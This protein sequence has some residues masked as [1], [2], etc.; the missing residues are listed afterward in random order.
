MTISSEVTYGAGS[1]KMAQDLS[2]AE[3][4]AM[5]DV[6]RDAM[7]D[8][9]LPSFSATTGPGITAPPEWMSSAVG[10][11][12]GQSF[13]I[14]EALYGDSKSDRYILSMQGN[15]WPPI[16][17]EPDDIAP[18]VESYR[19]NMNVGYNAASQPG[20]PPGLAGC[21]C[22]GPKMGLGGCGCR[23]NGLGSDD[24]LDFDLHTTASYN[25]GG[26][27]LSGL[28][29]CDIQ[30]PL[31]LSGMGFDAVEPASEKA[32]R[33]AG[34]KEVLKAALQPTTKFNRE[35][36]RKVID[37]S[38]KLADL[39]EKRAAV[40]QAAAIDQGRS[41]KRAGALD[42][43][44][45]KLALRLF[46]PESG[47]IRDD[48]KAADM[49]KFR[50]LRKAAFD[51]GR[52]AVRDEKVK[53][54][55]KGLAEN[56]YGQSLALQKVAVAMLGNQ[57][58]AVA[59]YGK[60]FDRLGKE[61][62][63]LRAV[64]AKQKA[65]WAQ[66]R[67][68]ELNGLADLDA[69]DSRVASADFWEAELDGME[70]AEDAYLGSLEGWLRRKVKKAASKV[71]SVAKK[72]VSKV[73]SAAK[74]AAARARAAAVA[75][76]KRARDAAK[77]AATAAARRAAAA[78]KKAATKIKN[79]KIVKNTIKVAKPIARTIKATAKVAISPVKM[80]VRAG[81]RIAK[82]DFKG[83]MRSVRDTA[84]GT[85]KQLGSAVTSSVFGVMCAM[86]N[87]RLG[88]AAGQAIG[89]AVG[90][91]Y[92]GTA[93]G[94]VGREAGRKANDLNKGMCK[95][96]KQM[97]LTGDQK[98]NFRA[99]NLKK[100]LKITAKDMKRTTFSKKAMLESAM[101]IAGGMIPG[102]GAAASGALTQLGTKAITDV[103]LNLAKKK[104]QEFL[105]KK[106]GQLA[107]KHA[108]AIT[109]KIVPGKAGRVL[110]K[111]AGGVAST[112]ASGGKIDAAQL[113]RIAATQGK[114]AARR[115]ARK[116]GTRLAKHALGDKTGRLLAE[117]AQMAM[118][119]QGS[120]P[121]QM[122]QRAAAFARKQAADRAQR[123]AQKRLGPA[124][125]LVASA[126]RQASGA[127]KMSAEERRA[128]LVA[129]ARQQAKARGMQAARRQ[130]GTKQV[131]MAQRA[132]RGGRPDTRAAAVSF[133]RQQAR[134]PW[135][136]TGP[137][138]SSLFRMARRRG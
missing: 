85:I 18:T 119:A 7:P 80:T 52:R 68:H 16:W 67:V 117:G 96:M 88:R 55:A 3:D 53:Q 62:G 102:G 32:R 65:N 33:E 92:G 98:L 9:D 73:S 47:D 70:I 19:N 133:A 36:A 40:A 107:G 94:S 76:A 39:V 79:S 111:A 75:A 60:V 44:T 63:A 31:G 135:G 14:D 69:I 116:Q 58:D 120:N 113:R 66:T 95:G 21:G 109:R 138:S 134:T 93:G 97:G 13:G 81:K 4:R 43:E 87:T 114:A 8:E 54:V 15:P 101:R 77:R 118:Q 100:S 74:A 124:G 131:D 90:T 72:T 103:G 34:F 50:S 12:R 130:F 71:K 105:K 83:A 86:E 91:V 82:G 29:R 11:F 136:R 38:E 51:E 89:Q 59:Y 49:T 45:Q 99:K 1:P 106:A 137:A 2:A 64:R 5:T 41:L 48:A 17:R 30:A 108:G 132:A 6:G 22:G 56:A 78:A 110:G 20:T 42:G 24:D 26:T 115:V 125:G 126:A 127:R 123:F 37:Q 27:R 104:G 121:Q 35:V 23:F 129:F 25:R 112:Y 122:R 46:D 61:S 57:P 28:D 10:N 84:K 128:R